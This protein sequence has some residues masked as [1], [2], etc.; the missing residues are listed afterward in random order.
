MAGGSRHPERLYHTGSAPDVSG[1]A[2]AS[3]NQDLQGSVL[4]R[5]DVLRE[6]LVLG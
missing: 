6:V 3:A 1:G 5:L 4:P 2:V